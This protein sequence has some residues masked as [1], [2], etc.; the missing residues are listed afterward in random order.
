MPS[1]MHVDCIAIELA[2]E[3]NILFMGN[4]FP[5]TNN[6]FDSVF[7]PILPKKM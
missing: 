4:F 7:C 2:I 3:S 6:R 5:N 1:L